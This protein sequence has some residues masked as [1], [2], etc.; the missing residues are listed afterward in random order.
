V[1]ALLMVDRAGERLIEQEARAA[2]QA[3]QDYLSAVAREEGL[4]ALVD[5]L[6]SRERLQGGGFR[7]SLT[8]AEG[9]PLAGGAAGLPARPGAWQVVRVGEDGRDTRWQV[10]A[11]SLPTG[12]RLVVAQ[13]LDSRMAFRQAVFQSSALAILLAVGA[14]I[15]AGIAVNSMLLTRARTIADTAERIAAGDMAARVEVHTPG[16]VFDRLGASVNLM[17][18][19]IEELMTGLRTVTD[20]LAHDLRTPLGRLK[21]ALSRA[22][23][24]GLDEEARLAAVEQAHAHV[25]H[26][27]A[28]F[29]ALLD[30]AQAEAGLSRASME[31]VDLVQ[32]VSD[33]GEL[34]SPMLEDAGQTL[35]VILPFRPVRIRAHELLLR[36]AVGNLLH[37]ASRHAGEGAAVVLSLDVVGPE[38]WVTVADDGPGIPPE[39]RD[40]VQERFVRLDAA[41]TTSGTGLGLAIVAACAKLHDGALSL[42]DNDPGLRAVMKI[43][44]KPH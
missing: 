43:R 13:S 3:E 17:L 25:E 28:T 12:E 24:P 4:Q 44:A 38:A 27:L 8:D 15:A 39:D 21:G 31:E 30:I 1:V 9:R 35:E 11:K 2:A 33:V 26:T 6:N 34:F 14:S 22:M 23:A 37:N 18:S 20:S 42:E 40:R 32:A 36:Q 10:V 7:Y 41:R 16:D 29:S 5:T 19:R